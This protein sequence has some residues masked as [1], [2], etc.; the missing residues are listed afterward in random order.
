VSFLLRAVFR[1]FVVPVGWLVLEQVLLLL[2]LLLLLL[3]R[4][5]GEEEEE[6]LIED[7]DDTRLILGILRGAIASFCCSSSLSSSP[8][9]YRILSSD[10]LAISLSIA[11]EA[12]V[13]LRE[14]ISL[15]VAR[16]TTIARFASSMVNLCFL[17]ASNTSSSVGLPQVEQESCPRLISFN[18][19]W[20][21]RSLEYPQRPISASM[22]VRT[23]ATN[24]VRARTSSGTLSRD[25]IIV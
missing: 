1:G 2:L 16:L 20:M 10:I 19:M 12:V 17:I 3:F 15:R 13:P 11:S 21:A 7:E 14:S 18:R 24:S 9:S 22:P 25:G 4:M 8:D 5:E 23:A 6:G